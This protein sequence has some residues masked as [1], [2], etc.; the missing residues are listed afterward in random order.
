M[1]NQNYNQQPQQPQ[2]PVYQQPMPPMQPQAPKAPLFNNDLLGIIGCTASIVGFGLVIVS[3]CAY[4]AVYGLILNI[5]AILF[6]AG[7]CVLSFIVGNSR[8][9]SGAPRGT[10][11]TLGIIFGAAAFLLAIFAIFTTGCRACD[12]CSAENAVKSALRSYL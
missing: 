12:T 4:A 8:I 6:S 11:A 2:Q 1:N 3:L 10:V 7:G 5:L 9:K